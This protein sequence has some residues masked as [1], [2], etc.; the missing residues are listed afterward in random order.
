MQSN[1]EINI[2]NFKQYMLGNLAPAES[3]AIDLQ[4]ILDES[5]EEKLMWAES[6]L[7]ED[8]LDETLSPSEMELFR[9]NFL[10]SSERKAQFR[11]ISLMRN[12]A[13]NVAKAVPEKVSSKEPENFFWK[14]RKF[15]SLNLKPRIA[16]FALV[17][18]S[19]FAVG[20]F[21]YMADN[22][23]ASEM[24]FAELNQKDLSNVA[25]LENIFTVNLMSGTF[26][27]SSGTESK[28]QPDKLGD[29]VLFRLALPVAAAA[30]D[31]FK[32]ELVKDRK[33][34]FTQTNLRFYSNPNG[35]EL[36]LFLPASP[37][38]K[39]EYQ[40]KAAKETAKDSIFTYNFAVG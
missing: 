39:G 11:Q 2:S 7:M 12:Y 30:S 16:M 28:L 27:D 5:L 4:I 25:E 1:E 17:V 38:K 9:K 10:I 31:T 32:V 18:I 19:L 36:R 33:V 6:E 23:T 37:L 35:Q 13:R 8:Y 21:Y 14:L 22:Q 15:F 24:A 40:I 3:E 26:R 34:V 29:K 20:I